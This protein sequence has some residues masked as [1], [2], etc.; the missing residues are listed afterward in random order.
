MNQLL[1]DIYATGRIRGSDSLREW[2]VTEYGMPAAEGRLIHDLV[3]AERPQVTLEVG[4]ACGLST[5]WIC[6]ALRAVGGV[7]HI[8]MDPNQRDFDNT[9]LLHVNRAGYSDLLTFYGESSG[10]RG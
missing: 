2:P 3:R 6:D 4:L 5:L 9:G 7:Q 1:H 10:L 8:A